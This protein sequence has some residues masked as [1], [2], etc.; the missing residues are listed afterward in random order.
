MKFAYRAFD[1]KGRQI[2]D[3]FDAATLQEAEEQLRKKGLFVVEIAARSVAGQGTSEGGGFRLRGGGRTSRLR[4]VSGFMRQLSVLVAT[5]TPMVESIAALERQVPEGPWRSTVENLRQRLEEGQQLSEA[6]ASHPQYFDSVCQS[7]IAA[8][9]SGGQMDEMLKRLSQLVRQQLKVRSSIK[10]AM[11]YPSLLICVSIGVLGAMFGFVL[12]R[13]EGLFETLDAPLPPSTKI[14]MGISAWLK[15]WWFLAIGGAIAAAVGTKVY[16]STPS[17]R[18]MLHRTL[19]RLPQF[20][21]IVRSLATARI[22]RVLGVLLEGKVPLLEALQLT[23]DATG[24]L[25]YSQVIRDA[26]DRV[27]RGDNV[28]TA[29]AQSGLIPQAVVEAVKSGEKTGRL[30]AV[31]TSVADYLDEDNELIV[32]SLAS[33]IEPMILLLLG[34]IVGFVAISMFLPLFDLTSG[35]GGAGGAQ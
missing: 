7:L 15:D 12:P 34:L 26:E 19:V 33:I 4:E 29:F 22:A 32:K 30:A 5:G 31:L 3:V 27:V 24:N 9:E 1:L 13:F 2:D 25:C 17:G 16:L 10:G 35:A 20:G 11:V 28:S 23:R 18:F 8:G 21:K 14:M 6:M